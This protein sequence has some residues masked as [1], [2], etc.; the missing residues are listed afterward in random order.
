MDLQ[1]D[2]LTFDDHTLSKTINDGFLRGIPK[3]CSAFEL[4]E[5]LP[6]DGHVSFRKA[7]S[8]PCELQSPYSD[9]RKSYRKHHRREIVSIPYRKCHDAFEG[10]V[11]TIINKLQ[12]GKN[13]QKD[14]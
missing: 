4:G 2:P 1:A 6:L 5:T 12:S 14:L 9:V 3:A 7:T 11:V 8:K 10:R 13:C